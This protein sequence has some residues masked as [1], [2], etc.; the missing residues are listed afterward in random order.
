MKE[1]I[2][3]IALHLFVLLSSVA[4]AE[5]YSGKC[6]ENANWSLDTETGM[7]E[8]TG[9]GKMEDFNSSNVPWYNYNAFVRI[10]NVSD[11]TNIGD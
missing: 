9:S 2:I 8:I 10:V 5:I 1:R 6:G 11:V 3:I 7:L 4:N